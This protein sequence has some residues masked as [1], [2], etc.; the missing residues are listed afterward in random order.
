MH[1]LTI[2]Q[3]SN[4]FVFTNNITIIQ[5]ICIHQHQLF[6]IIQQHHT[7]SHI[8]SKGENTTPYDKHHIKHLTIIHISSYNHIN[9]FTKDLQSIRP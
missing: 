2:S 6:H 5:H 9:L 3:S 1:S 7:I 4:I 8:P